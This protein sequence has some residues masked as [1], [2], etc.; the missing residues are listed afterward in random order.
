MR[1]QNPFDY[2][3]AGCQGMCMPTLISQANQHRTAR[4][5]P[6]KQRQVFLFLQLVTVAAL[7]VYLGQPPRLI[8]VLWAS[9]TVGPETAQWLRYGHAPSVRSL[10]LSPNYL[11]VL[12]SLLRS[13][14]VQFD[15]RARGPRDRTARQI[16]H[17]SR[18]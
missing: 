15:C 16:E 1:E 6:D 4:P 9:I 18:D 7:S 10:L 14:V 2:E 5:A 13:T 3:Q 12:L 17:Q 11:S 8:I